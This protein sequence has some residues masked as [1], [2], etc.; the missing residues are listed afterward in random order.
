MRVSRKEEFGFEYLLSQK[1]KEKKKKDVDQ[2]GFKLSGKILLYG[3]PTEVH[4]IYLR[5]YVV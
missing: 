5:V 1:R 4:L 3:L 2:C